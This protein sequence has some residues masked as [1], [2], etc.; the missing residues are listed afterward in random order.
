[1]KS[2]MNLREYVLLVGAVAA[3]MGGGVILLG[4][5]RLLAATSLGRAGPQDPDSAAA[6]AVSNQAGCAGAVIILAGSIFLL[7]GLIFLVAGLV[8]S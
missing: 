2:A 4:L 5:R 1:M 6:G 3:A 7:G 8:V